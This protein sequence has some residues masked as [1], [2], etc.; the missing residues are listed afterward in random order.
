MTDKEN[1]CDLNINSLPRDLG[2]NFNSSEL[3]KLGEKYTLILKKAFYFN[4][5]GDYL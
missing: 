5:N 2:D 1:P 4:I 3:K